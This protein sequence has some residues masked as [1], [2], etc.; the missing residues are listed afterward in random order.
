MVRWLFAT[1]PLLA[2]AV[3]FALSAP[4]DGVA[5]FGDP[6]F[7]QSQ[8]PSAVVHNAYPGDEYIVTNPAGTNIV[9]I[10][11]TT[12]AIG[13]WNS[14]LQGTPNSITK[15]VFHYN[16]FNDPS[17]NL[18]VRFVSAATQNAQ[19]GDN[20]PIKDTAA[21]NDFNGNI[22]IDAARSTPGV[23]RHELG[24][25]LW[26]SDQYNSNYTCS[27]ADSIM[28]G[29]GTGPNCN[30]A[31][32]EADEANFRTRYEPG[33]QSAN[34]TFPD[35]WTATWSALYQVGEIFT[36]FP[37]SFVEYLYY[38]R[39]LTDTNGGQIS[40]GYTITDDNRRRLSYGI[41][42]RWCLFSQIH[43][44]AGYPGGRAWSPPSQFTCVSGAHQQSAGFHVA[45]SDR[46]SASGN[47]LYLRVRNLS[48]FTRRIGL[49]GP[50]LQDVGCGYAD[51]SNGA[52]RTCAVTLSRG[53]YPNLVWYAWDGPSIVSYGYLD[54]H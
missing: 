34:A 42:S 38:W 28:D 13:D 17:A 15:Y 1:T 43:N 35:T 9:Q 14:R 51:I 37:P 5:F 45:T 50:S 26:Y 20:P 8:S 3:A 22:W 30:E 12:S 2:L 48:G 46:A 41:G 4:R 40:D 36:Y 29:N 21:C 32:T 6:V 23:I 54:F 19:C 52:T 10:Q 27:L 24:H 49:F 7:Y 53:A 25:S 47:T 31:I 44:T 33:L 39:Q 18:F 11:Q 16:G